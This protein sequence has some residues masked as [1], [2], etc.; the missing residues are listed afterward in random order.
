MIYAKNIIKCNSWFK[1]VELFLESVSQSVNNFFFVDLLHNTFHLSEFFNVGNLRGDFFRLFFGFEVNLMWIW[2]GM[3]CELRRWGGLKMFQ[4][5]VFRMWKCCQANW[6]IVMIKSDSFLTN[7]NPFKLWL[8]LILLKE[9][10]R[11]L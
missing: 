1:K 11:P 10:I 8:K 5:R 6:E 3:V 7:S 4:N 2:D 9:R